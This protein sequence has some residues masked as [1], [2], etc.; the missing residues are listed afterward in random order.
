MIFQTSCSELLVDTAIHDVEKAYKHFKKLF[1]LVEW[2]SSPLL[3]IKV[4]EK[5][6]RNDNYYGRDSD[7]IVYD[8]YGN[9]AYLEYGNNGYI[10]TGFRF[11]SRCSD[12]DERCFP[13]FEKAIENLNGKLISCDGGH[14]S[15]Y[16][17][18]KERKDLS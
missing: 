4:L 1:L 15:G 9:R 5:L 14:K 18:W 8:K 3:S 2:E 13:I 11:D 10:D 12:G 16:E 7:V 17:E 6:K